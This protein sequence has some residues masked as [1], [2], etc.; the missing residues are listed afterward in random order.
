[1]RTPLSL[2]TCLFAAAVAAATVAV[3][4]GSANA[5]ADPDVPHTRGL[6]LLGLDGLDG[7]G[8]LGADGSAGGDGVLARSQAGPLRLRLPLNL[9]RLVAMGT[10]VGP[11]ANAAQVR[12]RMLNE[13]R[14]A[15]LD[16]YVHIGPLHGPRFTVTAISDQVCVTVRRPHSRSGLDSGPCTAADRRASMTPLQDSAN[17]LLEA[18]SESFEYG[19]R[20]SALRET[21]APSSLRW[22]SQLIA[23]QGVEVS[24]VVDGNRDRL[25]DD[26]RVAFH[27]NN[28]SVCA[29]LPLSA[30]DSGTVTFGS[31]QRLVPRRVRIHESARA[32]FREMKRGADIGASLDTQTMT[33][34]V[35]NAA[36]M[37][38]AYSSHPE[39]RAQ[40]H[41]ERVQFRARVNNHVRFAC[42]HVSPTGHRATYSPSGRPG[43]WRLGRCR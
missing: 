36:G 29:S 31:C 23:P 20:N 6:E 41:G 1:M 32:V 4:A 21:L 10:P 34:R 39:A 26:G 18:A 14:D 40:V 30:S 9:A 22:V 43:T 27:A 16:E 13:M 5:V 38:R 11:H 12:R 37:A 15:A 3:P 17:L 35:R 25:D 2:V 19:D 8:G 28:R 33:R 42:Y 24:G 7:S